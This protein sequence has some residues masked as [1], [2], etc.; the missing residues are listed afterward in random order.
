MQDYV[1]ARLERDRIEKLL[2]ESKETLVKAESDLI[3]AME[4]NGVEATAKYEGLGRFQI[5]KP[6]IR[7]SIEQGRETDA[8]QYLRYMGEGD[9]IKET[10]HWKSLSSIIGQKVE[11]N[12]SLPDCFKYYFMNNV[13]WEK[14]Q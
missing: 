13:K 2:E 14:P 9:L 11:K 3:K 1:N 8:Y 12:E 4:D 6:S 7:V 10:I 5:C